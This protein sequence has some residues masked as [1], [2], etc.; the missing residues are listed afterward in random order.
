M[1]RHSTSSS[2][3]GL[4]LRRSADQLWANSPLRPSEYSTPVLGPI[5]LRFADNAFSRIEADLKGKS[6][7]RRMIGKAD[8]QAR[9]VVYVP[10]ETRFSR[11]LRLPESADLGKKLNEAMKAIEKENEDLLDALQKSYQRIDN[12]T[13]DELLKIMYSILSGIPGDAFGKIYEYFLGSFAMKESQKGGECFTLP[14]MVDLMVN[15][16]EPYHG[17]LSG[18]LELKMEAS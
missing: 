1:K 2:W 8:Y 16:I 3:T 6:T 7:G 11:L 14:N 10:E 4:T 17:R 5:F 18:H 12:S 9:G 13:L 15:V